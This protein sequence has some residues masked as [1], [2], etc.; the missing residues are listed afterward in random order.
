MR[1]LVSIAED[2]QK[3]AVKSYVVI[4]NKAMPT[5]VYIRYNASS[6][7]YIRIPDY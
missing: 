5:P 1:R 2:P 7:L 3:V 4:I 6:E